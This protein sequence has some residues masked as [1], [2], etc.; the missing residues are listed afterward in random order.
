MTQKHWFLLLS[1]ILSLT[2]SIG[3]TAYGLL[4]EYNRLIYTMKKVLTIVIFVLLI[5]TN[6][7]GANLLVEAESFQN[8]GGWVVDQQFSDLM[9]SDYLMAHGLGIHVADASTLVNFPKKGTYE[10]Y[11]RT[12]NWT[13]PWFSGEGPGKFNLAVNGKLLG[14]TLGVTG[15]QW[16]WQRAGSV[17]IQNIENQLSLKDGTGFNGRCDAIYFTTE[18]GLFPPNEKAALASFRENCS[19]NR[20]TQDGGN[21][22][23]VVSGG[24]I[25][26]MCAAVAAARQGLK[27]ALIHDRPVL[28]GNNSSEVR[29]HLGGRLN[30]E[31]YAELG[32]MIREFGPS[33]Y[34]NAEPKENYED[35]KKAD[36]IAAEKNVHL[37]SNMRVFAVNMN[38]KTIKSVVARHIENGEKIEF[39]APLFVDCTGDGTVGFLA[40]ADFAIGRESRA[41][42]QESTA[43]EQAD[44]MTMGSSVQWN[45]ITTKSVEPF[46][47]FRYGLNVNESNV[48]KIAK[49]D[50]NWE[51]GMNRDQIK[52]FEYIRDYGLMVVFSN[53]SYLKNEA[54]DQLAYDTRKLSWV[55]FIAGKRESRRLLG[56]LILT[57]ND[58]RNKVQYPDGSCSSS[59]TIDLHYPDPENTKR[60]PGMEFLSIAK[61]IAIMPYP[62]PYRCFYSRNVN[63]LFMAGRNISVTHVALGTVRV[64][65]TT[66]MM[67]E[68]VGLAASLC[69][70][71]QCSPR[72]LYEQHLPELISCL[73]QGAGKK[74]TFD[75]QNYN[76]GSSL[77]SKKK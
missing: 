19:E 4:K 50:W 65:R 36:W 56:D 57:E 66:G 22:D 70:R 14:N 2:F 59:W 28:G 72:V 11:V 51:T 15:N 58:I 52:D 55:A 47:I 43:P 13:S 26:G 25:A 77:L 74:D 27:V 45:S 69:K 18:K 31:P 8:K 48:L 62:I 23:L 21:F 64:M 73:K 40:G 67:G 41:A 3:Q 9:G 16:E 63:N 75:N 49:G 32:N 20:T 46:P 29:V 44:L 30:L 54:P 34:G 53:W 37:F 68:V 39:V 71:N 5:C 35:E 10:V 60:F 24:G 1:G 7:Q 38:G 17:N 76:E 12:F 42:Y 6:S 61:H 33:R